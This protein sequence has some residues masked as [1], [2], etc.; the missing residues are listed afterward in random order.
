MFRI[1]SK[2]NCKYCDKLKEFLEWS[3]KEKWWVEIRD[4]PIHLIEEL[5]R[6][7]DQT[8]YPFVFL[9]D[10][11]IGGYHEVVRNFPNLCEKIRNDFDDYNHTWYKEMNK[12]RRIREEQERIRKG[13]KREEYNDT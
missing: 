4:P 5:K 7:T 6:R 12:K 13:K 9:G 8:T 2:T 3:L 1:Y 10:E 11:F